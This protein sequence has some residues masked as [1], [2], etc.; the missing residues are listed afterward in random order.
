MQAVASHLAALGEGLSHG[1]GVGGR[2]LSAEVGGLMTL[3]ALEALAADPSTEVVVLIS[4]PA[5]TSAMPKIETALRSLGKP[6]VV[7]CLG[8]LAES[9]SAGTRV[10]TLED[11][12]AAA[13]ALARGRAWAPCAFSDAPAVRAL[14]TR[15]SASKTRGE[16]LLGLYTG[17]TLAHE[18]KLLLEPLLG[19]IAANLG[20]GSHTG[21]HRILDLGA[22]EFTV[23]RPHPMIDP[24]GRAARV[25]EAGRSAQVGVLLLDLVLGRAV[26]ENP[27]RAL[28]AAIREARDVADRDGRSLVVIASVLGTERD[29]Q[30]LSAQIAALES[31]GAFLLPS[32][33][34][35]ARFAALVA[36]P[37]LVTTL[38]GGTR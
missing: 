37:A 25:R 34:Q 31:A 28:A 35:A 4:K 1:I 19:P 9:D 32:N 5:A 29:P 11:A 13:A 30:G 10:S 36:R 8:A 15:V 21:L 12:A 26:H 7:C 24:D 20:G 6:V 3:L 14:L 16:G 17:G 18:A 38:L 2:D 23:G 22:D 27:A 33:G